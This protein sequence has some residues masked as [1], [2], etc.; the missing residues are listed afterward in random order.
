MLSSGILTW[1][2]FQGTLETYSWY[3]QKICKNREQTDARTLCI[4]SCIAIA[5][6]V[7][8]HKPLCFDRGPENQEKDKRKQISRNTLNVAAQSPA[9]QAPVVYWTRQVDQ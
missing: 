5:K 9:G 3:W 8:T 2:G 6:H 4:D 7:G 1:R